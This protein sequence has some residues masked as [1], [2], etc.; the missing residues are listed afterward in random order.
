MNWHFPEWNKTVAILR[1][2]EAVQATL[3]E[4]VLKYRSS[5]EC[6]THADLHF[7]NLLAHENASGE[8]LYLIDWEFAR[9]LLSDSMGYAGCVLVRLT[10]GMHHYPAIKELPS[11]QRLRAEG[12]CLRMGT[13]LLQQRREITS[14]E[15]VKRLAEEVVSAEG[16]MTLIKHVKRLAEEELS[17]GSLRGCGQR[18]ETKSTKHVKCKAE[19]ELSTGNLR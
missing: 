2:D 5:K 3:A 6:L 19:E 14:I 10:I 18:G 16:E 12:W 1:A 15:H 13:R 4:L 9:Q 7:G 11:Q 17:A 8:T